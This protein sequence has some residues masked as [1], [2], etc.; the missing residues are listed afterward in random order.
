MAEK[1]DA[2]LDDDLRAVMGCHIKDEIT[3][4]P[5]KNPIHVSRPEKSTDMEAQWEPVK[6]PIWT[7]KLR[8]TVK[9]C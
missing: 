8:D 5:R 3:P 2:L 7:D 4:A 9:T 6:E 1:N